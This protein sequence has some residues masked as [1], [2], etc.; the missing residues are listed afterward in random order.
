MSEI[1]Y[2]IYK[3][4]FLATVLFDFGVL[5]FTV[6][7]S[8]PLRTHRW[9][10][11]TVALMVLWET[12][13]FFGFF[14]LPSVA[15][16]Q[17]LHRLLFALGPLIVLGMFFFLESFWGEGKIKVYIKILLTI[18]ALIFT[19]ASLG[20]FV[21]GDPE[22]YGLLTYQYI[23]TK[24][25]LFQLYH[26]SFLPVSIMIFFIAWK[27]YRT[28]IGEKQQQERYVIFAILISFIFG[29]ITNIWVPLLLSLT[30]ALEFD[31]ANYL[32]TLTI[33]TGTIGVTIWTSVT[34]YA[35]TRH[36]LMSF[37][38]VVKR[39]LIFLALYL[40]AVIAVAALYVGII[41]QYQADSYLI[42]ILVTI[43]VLLLIQPIHT[44]VNTFFW[45][46]EYDLALR[47]G[48]EDELNTL[49]AKFVLPDL[50]L[51]EEM[52]RP[53][54]YALYAFDPDTMNTDI[55]EFNV[56]L[57]ISNPNDVV[58]VRRDTELFLRNCDGVVEARN[59]KPYKELYHVIKKHHGNVLL[60]FANEYTTYGMLVLHV[61]DAV[62]RTT[63]AK[64]QAVLASSIYMALHLY[65]VQRRVVQL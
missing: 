24:G 57:P 42:G 9:F 62:S 56:E 60:V 48:Q 33:V 17:I 28:I 39:G 12:G 49:L 43:I 40:A 27:I 34:A 8:K 59:V 46:E 37:H 16:N 61:D 22:Y 54:S 2:V 7:H 14:T 20:G 38:I 4:V 26:I 5:F 25:P 11:I 15:F 3:Y 44:L 47:V 23:L 35:I 45:K 50:R 36:K 18:L 52:T 31:F 19:V 63:L 6:L 10:I 32:L 64:H 51:L 65:Y 29:T 53:K 1:V 21:V 41:Q 13:Q 30:S 55:I 58:S